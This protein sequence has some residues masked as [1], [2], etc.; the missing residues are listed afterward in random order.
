MLDIHWRKMRSIAVVTPSYDDYACIV[1]LAKDLERVSRDMKSIHIDLIV[2]NDSPWIEMSNELRPVTVNSRGITSIRI[3]QLKAN[4][5]HQ[6]AL[7]VG[8]AWLLPRLSEYQYIVTMD[9][10]GEDNPSDIP[11]MIDCLNDANHPALA[12]AARR[13]LRKEKFLFRIGYRLYKWLTYLLVGTRIDYGNFICFRPA[14]VRILTKMPETTIHIAAS[15]LRSRMPFSK[16]S[17]DRRSRYCGE[18]RMGGYSSLILH[19]F[20]AYSVF[21]D[22]IAVRLILYVIIGIGTIIL[23][24]FA[25]GFIRFSG[26]IDVFPGWASIISITLLG[27]GVVVAINLFGL[28]LLLITLSRS[29]LRS[30]PL[31]LL[32]EFLDYQAGPGIMPEH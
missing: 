23:G 5:G 17:S 28:A 21:G 4:L 18:S 26:I 19:A 22:R 14:A 1:Q 29:S 6:A 32:E 10:D 11:T 24:V 25:A 7:A 8:L 9:A 20:R 3:L 16:I 30:T 13:G 2:V 15:I 31:S 27:L 12:C